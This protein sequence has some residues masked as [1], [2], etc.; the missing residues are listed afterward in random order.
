MRLQTWEPTSTVLTV[1]PVKV[2]RKRM[3]RSAVPPPDTN[4]PC[5]CGDQAT[6][7]T[8]AW[9]SQ[10]FKI[11][12]E[13]WPFH[14]RS[15]LSLPPEHS[16]CSSGDHFSPHTSCRWPTNLLTKEE[17]ILKSLWR[18][19]LSLE[20]VLSN[21]VLHEIAP[22]LLVWPDNVL[23]FF[24]FT[25]SHIWTSPLLVPIEK[26]GPLFDHATEVVE[27]ET[28]RSVSLFT[29]EFDAFQR[30]TQEDNPTARKFCVDQSIRLR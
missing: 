11:G 9:W 23:V 5:W 7:L 15:L 19:V 2:L 26:W 6:A 13:E 14:T 29:F 20:P 3:V 17:L 22:T 12:S 30:Y 1:D 21:E 28:P 25:T 4:S 27:S 24:I 18:M 8:A 16:C 10:Y